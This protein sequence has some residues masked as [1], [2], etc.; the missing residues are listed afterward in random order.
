MQFFRSCWVVLFFFYSF[1]A[2]NYCWLL[3]LWQCLYIM[4]LKILKR[5][6]ELINWN[7]IFSGDGRVSLPTMWELIIFC[8]TCGKMR[9]SYYVSMNAIHLCTFEN[10]EYLYFLLVSHCQCHHCGLLWSGDICYHCSCCVCLISF[11]VLLFFL[12][13]RSEIAL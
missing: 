10:Y 13:F 6:K 2:S 12:L 5:T 11:S 4:Y 1:Q 7:Y 8:V 3:I 9:L